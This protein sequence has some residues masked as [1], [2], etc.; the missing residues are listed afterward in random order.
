[1]SLGE[2]LVELR[3]RIILA[4]LGL[5]VGTALCG[6][7][8][9]DLLTALLRPYYQALS[10]IEQ[11]QAPATPPKDTP[12]TDAAPPTAPAGTELAPVAAKAVDERLAA[13]EA[14]IAKLEEGRSATTPSAS[15]AKGAPATATPPSR[16]ILSGPMTGYI[17]IILMCLIT[18]VI[19]ASPWVIYQIWAF[20]GVG[21]HPHERKHV[22]IYG[23]A[24]F[25]LFIGGGSLFY[26]Y[27]LPVGLTA[28]MSP[29]AGIKING[30][31]LIDPSFMLD[32]Y[33]YFVALMTLVFGIAF[34][35]PLVVMFIERIGLVPLKTLVKQQ[36]LVI[37]IMVVIAALITPTVDPV[38]M[39]AMAVPLILLY[40]LGLLAAWFTGRKRR[41]LK[42]AE[43]AADKARETA[44]EAAIKSEQNGEN[45]YGGDYPYGGESPGSGES[46]GGGGK[47]LGSGESPGGGGE[48]LG[49]GESPGGGGENLGSGESPG[50]GGESPSSGESSSGENSTGGESPGDGESPSGGGEEKPPDNVEPM[51]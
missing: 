37:L 51:H 2:H 13:L 26:F 29:T 40:E 44:E 32:E 36:R 27:I 11:I 8:Y 6:I 18:G 31:S 34:Q 15:G 16:L 23:P 47:N 38:S 24:S 17:M 41:K 1:M 22:Y 39:T 46:P 3:H 45:P 50:G 33:L 42:E 30:A 21:L 28:L 20:V 14:R 19:I 25:L 35:T 10:N 49:S 43:E 12:K 4:L 9:E 48:N 7:F 5:L